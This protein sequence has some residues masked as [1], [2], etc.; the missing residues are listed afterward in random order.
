MSTTYIQGARL[1][2]WP[3]TPRP[4][5]YYED[6][7][8]EFFEP[9]LKT[10]QYIALKGHMLDLKR[11]LSMRGNGIPQDDLIRHFIDLRFFPRQDRGEYNFMFLYSTHKNVWMENYVVDAAM[12]NNHEL[13]MVQCMERFYNFLMLSLL[14]IERP[15]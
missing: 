14:S 4:H 9:L 6:V 11:V 7:N 3:L 15:R 2:I 5:P 1:V 8:P 13:T 10:P 12:L